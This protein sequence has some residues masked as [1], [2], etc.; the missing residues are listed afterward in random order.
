MHSIIPLRWKDAAGELTIGA[1]QGSYPGMI[2]TR[3]FRIVLVG[4]GHGAGEAVTSRGDREIS[5]NGTEMQ[6]R[7]NNE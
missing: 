2:G 1:R 7:L 4:K 5:Y 6:V 3:Q